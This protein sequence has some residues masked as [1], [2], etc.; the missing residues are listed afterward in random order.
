MGSNYYTGDKLKRTREEV[1]SALA[2]M[3][4]FGE[5][6]REGIINKGLFWQRIRYSI[7]NSLDNSIGLGAALGEN[8][9]VPNYDTPYFNHIMQVALVQAHLLH[10]NSTPRPDFLSDKNARK[11][12][13]ETI[14]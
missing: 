8:T 2:T 5:G 6:D 3:P 9:F 7:V 14:K 10:P 13:L 1:A 11:F 12:G 4:E